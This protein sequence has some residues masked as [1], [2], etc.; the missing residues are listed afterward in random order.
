MLDIYIWYKVLSLGWI[1]NLYLQFHN[2]HSNGSCARPYWSR[3]ASPA[4]ITGTCSGYSPYDALFHSPTLSLNSLSLSLAL[5]DA[6]CSWKSA[7]HFGWQC[8]DDTSMGIAS[9]ST[10]QP[11]WIPFNH[12]KLSKKGILALCKCLKQAQPV[13]G[14]S[15]CLYERADLSDYKS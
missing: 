12:W 9:A 11:L 4:H 7:F 6:K 14:P 1:C 3:T 2:H 15:V 10:S 13:I 8:W 5:N